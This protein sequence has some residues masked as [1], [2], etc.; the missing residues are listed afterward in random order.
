[1][2]TASDISWQNL[3]DASPSG[4]ITYDE[5]AGTVLIKVD[6]FT[7]LN[8]TALTDKGVVPFVFKLLQRLPTAEASA[9]AASGVT[10][11]LTSFKSGTYSAINAT[12]GLA[13]VSFSSDFQVPINDS[14]V[15]GT[16]N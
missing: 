4:A 6:T 2:T 1:M 15:I 11:S 9:N 16:N 8:T 7:G 3:A 14:A 13:R 10:V 12:T 5:T